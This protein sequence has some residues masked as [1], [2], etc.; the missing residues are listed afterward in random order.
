MMFK[1]VKEII[2]TGNL[3]I[4]GRRI[5][6][7]IYNCEDKDRYANTRLENRNL[8]LMNRFGNISLEK[9]IELII[10]EHLKEL[11]K[12]EDLIPEVERR[13]CKILTEQY[14]KDMKKNTICNLSLIH[15]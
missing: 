3:K 10:K 7:T 2:K 11:I 9:K 6:T 13:Y 14:R 8:D 1:T 12:L 15:I 5:I 4:R